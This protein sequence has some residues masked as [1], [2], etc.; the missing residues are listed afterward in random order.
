MMMLYLYVQ[1]NQWIGITLLAAIALML[2]FCLVYQAMWQPRGVE[3]QAE[4]IKVKDLKTFFLWLRS[5]VPWAIVIVVLISFA[6]TI[7]TLLA[8]TN[9]PPNW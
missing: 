1:Q 8:K 4:T 6:F 3:G 9:K 2:V 5:F 7:A